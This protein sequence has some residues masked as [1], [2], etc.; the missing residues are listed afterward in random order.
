[1]VLP[2][3]SFSVLL[4]SALLLEGSSAAVVKMPVLFHCPCPLPVPRELSWSVLGHGCPGLLLACR[5]HS[6]WLIAVVTCRMGLCC[7]LDKNPS[8]TVVSSVLQAGSTGPIPARFLLRHCSLSRMLL[9][10]LTPGVGRVTLPCLMKSRE[11]NK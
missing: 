4:Q 1:M 2:C 6:R 5:G 7:Q 9:E 10:A 11:C 3:E 8:G